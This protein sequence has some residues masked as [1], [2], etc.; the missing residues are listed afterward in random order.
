M[1]KSRVCAISRELSWLLAI[2]PL[3]VSLA[4]NRRLRLP[5]TNSQAQT[6]SRPPTQC[7]RRWLNLSSVSRAGL[8]LRSEERRV[9]KECR[10]WWSPYHSKKK[11]KRRSFVTGCQRRRRN[12]ATGCPRTPGE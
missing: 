5:F 8:S 3:T 9:G 4:E 1:D 12:C 2:T 7:E 10:S 11:T 6:R